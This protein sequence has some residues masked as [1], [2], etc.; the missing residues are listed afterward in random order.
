MADIDLK[1]EGLK[2]KAN[3]DFNPFIDG[4]KGK[5]KNEQADIYN[6]LER[7]QDYGKAGAGILGLLS[8]KNIDL[9]PIERGEHSFGIRDLNLDILKDYPELFY[10]YGNEES[11]FNLEATVGGDER[12]KYMT[13]GGKFTFTEGGLA[14]LMGY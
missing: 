6:F 12:D 7:N 11:P 2:A 14:T 10:M 9:P 13:V 5:I 3:L 1:Y 4:L 8:G